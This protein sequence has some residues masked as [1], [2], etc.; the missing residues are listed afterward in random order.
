MSED[1]AEKAEIVREYGPFPGVDQIGGVTFDGRSVWFASGDKLTAID[2]E[3][4]GTCSSSPGIASR[5]STRRTA[6]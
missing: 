1:S 5:R 6:G 3:T 4:A 2:P